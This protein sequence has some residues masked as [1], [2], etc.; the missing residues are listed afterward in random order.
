M[1][2]TCQGWTRAQLRAQIRDRIL[3]YGYTIVNVAGHGPA[4]PAFAYTVGLS[5][6]DH[7]ELI[8]F[9][10]HPDCGYEALDPIARRVVDSGRRFDEDSGLD[11]VFGRVARSCGFLTR[12]HI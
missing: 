8:I 6:V 7:P 12:R 9:G 1:C 5:R 4:S 10:C 11:D 2:L 3:T